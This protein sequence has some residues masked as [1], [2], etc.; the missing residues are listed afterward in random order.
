MSIFRDLFR[1]R[2][3]SPVP[4]ETQLGTLVG[5]G[6]ALAP[7]LTPDILTSVIPRDTLEAEPYLL[8]LTLMGGGGEDEAMGSGFLSDHIWHFDTECIENHG[9]YAAIARRMQ[10]LAQGDL[11]LEEIQ[12]HV[13]VEEGE[14]WI[15]FRLGG[16]AYRWEAKVEDD[17]VDDRILTRFADLLVEQ[18]RGRRFTYI[19]LGGQDCLIGCSTPAQ[20]SALRER[21]GLAVEWLS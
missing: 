9:D 19:D 2:R 18:R 20:R 10:T 7:G 17:W 16:Q 6:I 13:D 8:T 11:P 21:T 12:D 1:P 5:C 3:R 15:A 14:A 4:L